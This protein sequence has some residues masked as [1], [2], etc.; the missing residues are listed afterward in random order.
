MKREWRI[1]RQLLATPEGQQRWDRAYQQ[2]LKWTPA[3]LVLAAVIFMSA[4][5][6]IEGVSGPSWTLLNA[7]TA[8]LASVL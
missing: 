5:L 6:V 3:G 2:L 8:R 7:F 4:T 1:R